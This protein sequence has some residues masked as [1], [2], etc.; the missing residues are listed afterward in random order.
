MTY[1]G[2]LTSGPTP[3]N[4]LQ[5]LRNIATRDRELPIDDLYYIEFDV[6]VSLNAKVMENDLPLQSSL[7]WVWQSAHQ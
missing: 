7:G 5:A 4:T 2:P 6:H 1:R 3:E